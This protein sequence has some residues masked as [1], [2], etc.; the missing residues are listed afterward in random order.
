MFLE[1]HGTR[2]ACQRNIRHDS[3]TLGRLSA[4]PSARHALTVARDALQ[5]RVE[6]M[7]R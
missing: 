5:L 3:P 7:R 1:R 4:R 6:T 2:C